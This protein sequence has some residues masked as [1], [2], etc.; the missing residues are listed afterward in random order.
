MYSHQHRT[1]ALKEKKELELQINTLI[2]NYESKW[3]QHFYEIKLIPVS[4]IKNNL[5]YSLQQGGRIQ[6]F[7]TGDS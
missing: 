1:Q 2:A 3:K 5:P 7:V 4:Q 6:L